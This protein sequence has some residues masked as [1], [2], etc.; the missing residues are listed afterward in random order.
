MWISAVPA[1]VSGIAIL[2]LL[3]LPTAWA[4]RFRGLT[5]LA[6]S[7]AASLAIIS[8]T[9]FVTPV[10]GIRWGVV[11]VIGVALLLGLIALFLRRWLPVRSPGAPRHQW[12]TTL[13]TAGGLLLSAALICRELMRAIGAPANVSQTYDGVFH[14]NAVAQ[15]LST[16]DASPL[17]MNLANPAQEVGFYPTAWHATVA[18]VAQISGAAIPTATNALVL[19]VAA[20]VWPLAILFFTRPFHSGRASS[21]VLTAALAA[22]FTA[23]PYLLIAWGV[24]YPNF[25]STAFIPLALGFLYRA[26]RRVPSDGS[27]LPSLWIAVAG[28]TGAA[29]LAHP[30]A[31][32]GIGALSLPLLA[33]VA[34]DIS[35]LA[36]TPRQLWWRRAGL[37]LA[38]LTV[39]AIWFT[40]TTSESRSYESSFLRGI[41]SGVT[42][43]PLVDAKAWLLTALVLLGIGIALWKRNNRWLIASYLLTVLL[44]AVTIGLTGP[45]RDFLTGG[46][47]NDA[48]R[49]AALLPIAAIPLAVIA[50][51]W[52]LEHTVAWKRGPAVVSTIIFVGLVV[53]LGR[54]GS[55]PAQSG[56]IHSLYSM[57]DDSPLLSPDETQLLSRLSQEVPEGSLIAGDP[58]TGT[59]FA[60]S[61]GDRAV[62]F[63]HLKGSFG[64]EADQLASDFQALEPSQ[65]CA[66]TQDLGVEYIL[67]FGGPVYDTGNQK[68]R[69]KFAGLREVSGSP[70]LV[71]VDS[72]G[73]AFLYRVECG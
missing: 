10:F 67:D 25:L 29:A 35:H 59:A 17:H 73:D 16:G 46:W 51:S 68:A 27:P 4:L 18:L 31:L 7:L 50:G 71:K 5:L 43:A 61:V 54:A 15:I 8:L 22:I 58:W 49:I 57:N 36:L 44:F 66:L 9:S 11:P 32:L 23:F 52:I 70:V 30:N 20:G 13:A 21:I 55:I 56:W 47:Y 3:G 12:S 24:L 33:A 6:A 62:L 42:N 38:F 19:V 41:L 2:L 45:V 60:F 72:E 14:L 64:R 39:L 34:R 1:I 40:L 53:A 26:V 37:G 63:P 65:A 48:A 28:A 69:E